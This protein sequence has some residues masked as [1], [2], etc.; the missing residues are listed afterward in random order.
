MHVVGVPGVTAVDRSPWV[1][2]ALYQ[3]LQGCV[4]SACSTDVEAK[5]P[6]DGS[7]GRRLTPFGAPTS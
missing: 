2:S 4:G 7:F 1:A 5:M 6:G 3:S